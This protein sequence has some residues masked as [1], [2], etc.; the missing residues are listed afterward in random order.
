MAVNMKSIWGT[1]NAQ[2]YST[3]MTANGSTTQYSQAVNTPANVGGLTFGIKQKVGA[4]PFKLQV[5]MSTTEEVNADT[6]EWF[7][8]EPIE[9]LDINGFLDQAEYTSWVPTPSATRF[10]VPAGTLNDTVYFSVRAQ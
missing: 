5:T 2:A 3:T 7:D 6:A 10:V 1:N 8:W 4:L 9:E